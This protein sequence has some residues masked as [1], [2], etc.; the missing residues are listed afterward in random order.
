[1]GTNAKVLL[2]LSKECHSFDD[3]SGGM[4]PRRRPD[5]HDVGEQLDRRLSADRMSVITVYSGGR[6][7]AAYDPPQPHGPAPAEV[8]TGATLA[9]ID[10][11]VPGVGAAFNGRA[12]LDSWVDDPWSRGSYAAFLPGQYLRFAGLTGV[13]EVIDPLRGGAHVRLQPGIP[14]R[15]GG[16]RRSGSHP[17]PRRDRRARPA[18]CPPRSCRPPGGTNRDTRFPTE[19]P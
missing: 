5:V 7:G 3:W 11:V 17:G 14:E 19:S 10:A 13:A 1:M 8:G 4:L 12:W 16:E 6:V 2:Q 15:R 9:A 18:S